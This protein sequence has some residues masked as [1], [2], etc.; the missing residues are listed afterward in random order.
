MGKP[1]ERG[2]AAERE[3][4]W[5]SKVVRRNVERCPEDGQQGD[6]DALASAGHEGEVN[7]ESDIRRVRTSNTQHRRDVRVNADNFFSP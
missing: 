1:R 6:G 4:R 3:T 5:K 2:G 7:K